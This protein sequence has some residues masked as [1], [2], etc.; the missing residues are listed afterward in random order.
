MYVLREKNNQ[1]VITKWSIVT[2][3]I[4]FYA[5]MCQLTASKY[6]GQEMTGIKGERDN[7]VS[8]HSISFLGLP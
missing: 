1:S 8:R 3:D 7:S 2:E 6:I 5:Y 4:A